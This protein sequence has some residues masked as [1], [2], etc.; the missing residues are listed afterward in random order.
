MGSPPD[1][2]LRRIEVEKVQ[3]QIEAD[4][5]ALDG[6]S[7][8]WAL[9][10]ARKARNDELKKVRLN[11][12]KSASSASANIAKEMEAYTHPDYKDFLDVVFESDSEFYKLD[13]QKNLLERRLDVSRSILSYEKEFIIKSM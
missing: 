3:K 11:M 8:E 1:G 12:L 9:A 2:L 13:A 4:L 5:N 6:I 7:V 10:K